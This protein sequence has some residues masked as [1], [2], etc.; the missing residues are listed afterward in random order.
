MTKEEIRKEISKEI[1]QLYIKGLLSDMKEWA[2]SNLEDTMF[3][4]F[5]RL[6]KK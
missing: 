3:R 2:M 1:T 6:R 5:M 4:L